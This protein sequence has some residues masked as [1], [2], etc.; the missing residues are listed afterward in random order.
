MHTPLCTQP[1]A[2]QLGPMHSRTAQLGNANGV[3][4]LTTPP[5]AYTLFPYSHM[6][7]CLVARIRSA[8]YS[9]DGTTRARQVPRQHDKAMSGTPVHSACAHS[10]RRVHPAGPRNQGLAP[11]GRQRRTPPAKYRLFSLC[12]RLRLKK[13]AGA[14]CS[15]DQ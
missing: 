10:P 3:H 12:L 5:R 13:L 8:P 6:C 11:H 4:A 2:P 9:G 15:H 1:Q 14:A 7:A